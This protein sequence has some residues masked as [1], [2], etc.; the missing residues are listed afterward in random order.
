MSKRDVTT[1]AAHGHP[2]HRSRSDL[3]GGEA[4]R[5][6]K[7]M[8][9]FVDGFDALSAVPPGVTVF[10]S[11]RTARDHPDYE[12]ARACS[13]ILSRM[14]YA[15]ITG[16]GPGIMEAANRG[17]FDAGGCSVGLNISLPME[18]MP[19]VYQTVALHFDY[20]FARKVM[21]VKYSRAMLLFPGGFGTLD[22]F[23][24]SLTLIQTLK[25]PAYPVLCYGTEYWS[26]LIDWMRGTMVERFATISPGD[27][28]IF[29]VSDDVEEIA[30]IV[31]AHIRG[32]QDLCVLPKVAGAAA[33]VT[34]EGTRVGVSTRTTAFTGAHPDEPAI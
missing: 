19:N 20:F 26:P 32:G 1:N 11:A 30:N 21:L 28:D 18:Q 16:G 7:I 13:E 29:R 22:E 34:A 14:G 15:I 4:W 24:E 5:V 6:F 27:L 2:P 9:E 3:M 17:A 31:D 8:A 10:G 33:E 12:A 23:F 25:M